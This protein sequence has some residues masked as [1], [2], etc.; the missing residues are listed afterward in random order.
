[1]VEEPGLNIAN[2]IY[3][4]EG[5]IIIDHEYAKQR[6]KIGYVAIKGQ[7]LKKLKDTKDFIENVGKG[8]STACFK[9]YF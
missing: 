2:M 6:I 1:M 7:M 5:I 9:I 4:R 8:K 3:L